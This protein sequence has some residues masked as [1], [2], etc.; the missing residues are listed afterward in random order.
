MLKPDTPKTNK[1]DTS[2]VATLVESHDPLQC[3]NLTPQR[4]NMCDTPGLATLVEK[5]G[6]SQLWN[7]TI[8]NEAYPNSNTIQIKSFSFACDCSLTEIRPNHAFMR[9]C[10]LINFGQH[11]LLYSNWWSGTSR[12]HRRLV[13]MH[14]SPC[15]QNATHGCSYDHSVIE[16]WMTKLWQNTIT[17]TWNKGTCR[18]E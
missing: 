2:D 6:H 4:H 16:T 12:L 7:L 10:S 11:N 5:Y 15:A 18:S 9:T 14:R 1:G 13:P 17:P 3:W 8:Q